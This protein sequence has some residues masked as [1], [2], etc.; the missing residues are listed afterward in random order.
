MKLKIAEKLDLENLIHLRFE[1]ANYHASLISESKLKPNVKE[2]LAEHTIKAF[3]DK[4]ARL[5][6]AIEN[7]KI[8]GYTIGFVNQQH[9]LFDFGKQGLIDDIYIHSNYQRKGHGEDLI[10]ELF[11]WF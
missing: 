7:G 4:N 2:F 1:N 6:L 9:P 8:I 3:E 11:V 5:L 10:T